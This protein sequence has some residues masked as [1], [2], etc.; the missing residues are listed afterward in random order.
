MSSSLRSRR[1]LL[2][3]LSIGTGVAA[4][5]P[6][7]QTWRMRDAYA[8]T[9]KAPPR[10]IVF[11][12]YP[13][14]WSG[15]PPEQMAEP[16]QRHQSDLVVLENMELKRPKN[17]G[18]QHPMGRALCWTGR[19]KYMPGG[20]LASNQINPG[21]MSLDHHLGMVI[22]TKATPGL[23]V[24]R[25]GIPRGYNAHY[26]A[27]GSTLTP[28][29]D[30]YDV[31]NRVFRG[32]TIGDAA[33]P[34]DPALVAALARKKSVIS[35][36]SAEL[37]AF[38]KRLGPEDRL[39]A[40]AQLDALS[41]MEARLVTLK[42]TGAACKRPTVPEGIPVVPM[43]LPG[44]PPVADPTGNDYGRLAE[45]QMDLL[46]A[47]FACDL[48]RVQCFQCS[49]GGANLGF[50]GQPGTTWHTASH[51]GP[52]WAAAQRWVFELA[53][54]LGD[55]LKAIPEGPG[56]MLDNT[57]I[58]M[59]SE[60]GH[61]HNTDSLFMWSLGGKNMGIK[62]GQRLKFGQPG[63]GGGQSHNAWLVSMMNAMG[64][65]GDTYGDTTEI[66]GKGPLPGY[67]V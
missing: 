67:Q 50:V 56:N 43:K 36:V 45:A 7:L 66:A 15:S 17:E 35:S 63:F 16:L 18:F 52:G 38:R 58:V 31:Y 57:L 39:R 41:A 28:N 49:G 32:L 12:F 44:A 62:V 6:A 23:P 53:A 10:R 22:G 54:R 21:G 46:V 29:F 27:T 48:T 61:G 20:A 51:G 55:R 64:V 34:A 42:A 3:T 1:N 2:Q 26:D 5:A 14:G 13:H 65:P 37:S 40:D 47:A 8:Q 19:Y 30:P 24:L 33:A 25:Q 11:F 60:I 59:A 4:F 9:A